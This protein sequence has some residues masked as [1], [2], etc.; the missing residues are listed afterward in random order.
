M[1]SHSKVLWIEFVVES[2]PFCS[3]FSNISSFSCQLL[4]LYANTLFDMRVSHQIYNS[5]MQFDNFR[6]TTVI[7]QCQMKTLLPFRRI[8]CKLPFL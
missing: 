8:N 2:K 6:S 3:R 1:N 4:S 7:I 5:R